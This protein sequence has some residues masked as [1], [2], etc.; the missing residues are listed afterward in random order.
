MASLNSVTT[1]ADSAEFDLAGELNFVSVAELCE[2]IQPL[3]AAHAL[4]TINLVNVTQANS[5]G[6]AL[7]LEWL[8]RA[9]L[10]QKKLQFKNIPVNLKNIAEASGVLVLLPLAPDTI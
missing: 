1:T 8:K 2:K 10:A 7:L 6:L 4:I 3:L 9:A 5:A